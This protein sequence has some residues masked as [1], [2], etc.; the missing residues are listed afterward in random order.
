MPLTHLCL[1]D[2]PNCP[3]KILAKYY[4]KRYYT[5]GQ[6]DLR[7]LGMAAHIF[8]DYHCPDHWFMMKEVGKRIFV[9]FAPSWVGKTEE[10]VSKGISHFLHTNQANWKVERKYKGKTLVLNQAYMENL[11]SEL[12]EFLK[13]EPPQ[14]L[15][16]LEKQVKSRIFWAK[17]RSYREWVLL[18]IIILLPFFLFYLW[19]WKTKKTSKNDLLILFSI[20]VIFLIYFGLTYIY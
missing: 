20:W 19:R 3:A 11:K 4:V 2:D 18:G 6:K 13:T 17:I 12:S 15:L 1:D 5:E 7:L 9:P 14:D 16:T 8:Q 10:E